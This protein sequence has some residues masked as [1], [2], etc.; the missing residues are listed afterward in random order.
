MASA[1][2]T[3]RNQESS[4]IPHLDCVHPGK[5][6]QGT[7]EFFV[8][9]I[10]GNSYKSEMTFCSKMKKKFKFRKFPYGAGVKESVLLQLCHRFD[11]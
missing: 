4:R 6:V 10:F 2:L 8:L 9:P 3:A 7:W 11:S 5:L 1:L